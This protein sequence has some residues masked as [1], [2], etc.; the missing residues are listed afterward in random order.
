[1]SIDKILFIALIFLF[2]NGL[3]A[4]STI[5]GNYI[6]SFLFTGVVIIFSIYLISRI[7]F[8]FLSFFLPFPFS[9]LRSFIPI[10]LTILFISFFFIIDFSLAKNIDNFEKFDIHSNEFYYNASLKPIKS[11]SNNNYRYYE[12]FLTKPLATIFTKKGNEKLKTK[13]FNN[14]VIS[15]FLILILVILSCFGIGI[16]K[17]IDSFVIINIISLIII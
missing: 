13:N 17:L 11:S 8:K 5:T 9:F 1:M 3:G 10:L 7:S 2:F 15:S 14:I 12:F 4:T 16:F 6:L